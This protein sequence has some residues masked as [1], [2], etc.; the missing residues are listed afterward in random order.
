MI[1]AVILRTP[2]PAMVKRFF[3]NWASDH[4]MLCHF[5]MGTAGSMDITLRGIDEDYHISFTQKWSTTM[6]DVASY[7]LGKEVLCKTGVVDCGILE[8]GE[9]SEEVS[10]EIFKEILKMFGGYWSMEPVGVPIKDRRYFPNPIGEEPKDVLKERV[11]TSDLKFTGIFLN[12]DEDIGDIIYCVISILDPKGHSCQFD[13]V[14]SNLHWM[15]INN[16]IQTVT[17]HA[18]RLIKPMELKILTTQGTVEPKEF[19]EG[20]IVSCADYA[21]PDV[22]DVFKGL[23]HK[24]GGYGTM[25]SNKLSCSARTFYPIE[26]GLRSNIVHQVMVVMNAFENPPEQESAS[27]RTAVFQ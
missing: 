9:F 8:Y 5:M 27:E 15:K 23:L 16:G 14:G 6:I 24:F 21:S 20:W 13:N 7:S 19:T 11:Y 17:M 22:Q 18:S 12:K 1:T 2:D 26:A 10:Q 25:S 4:E 3:S